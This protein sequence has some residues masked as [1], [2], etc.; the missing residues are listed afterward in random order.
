MTLYRIQHPTGDLIMRNIFVVAVMS[1]L[2]GCSQPA[3]PVAPN[4]DDGHDHS[5]NVPIT[6]ADVKMP[7]TFA[8]LVTRIEQYDSQ[9][10]AVIESGKPES[11]HRALDELDIVVA[12]TMTLAQASV[13]EDR[14]AAVNEARQTIRN[15]FLEL[16]QSID[17]KEKPDYAAKEPAIQA[18][19]ATLKQSAEA[20]RAT[21][22]EK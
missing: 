3:P 5:H 12:E 20:P 19:I 8:E 17:A 21:V 14:M 22:P 10:K 16:H 4:Q 9:V 7:A 6:K 18:A 11:G 15:A 1:L 13:P 2:I